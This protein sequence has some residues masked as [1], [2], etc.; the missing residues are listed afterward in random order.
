MVAGLL[1]PAG[2][3][4]DDKSGGST[5]DSATTNVETPTQDATPT[6]AKSTTI[7]LGDSEYG[8]MLF[9]PSKQAIYMTPQAGPNRR[10]SAVA[11][12]DAACSASCSSELS[13]PMRF[14][15]CGRSPP[16]VP[17]H[18]ADERVHLG[19]LRRSRRALRDALLLDGGAPWQDI[20]PPA[21]L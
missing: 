6:A 13:L 9:D 16:V 7:T 14:R 17:E 11:S 8:S 4:D 20:E 5:N 15:C 12:P 1:A 19:A 3:G 10:D 2:C 21:V 18:V